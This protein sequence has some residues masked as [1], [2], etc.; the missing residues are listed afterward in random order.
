MSAVKHWWRQRVS[1]VV[2]IPL[3]L[4]LMW[5]VASVSGA[6]YAGALAF[7]ANPG[8]ALMVVLTVAVSAWHAV[9]GIQVVVEDYVHGKVLP[10]LL[11]W[12]TR[13]ACTLATLAACWAVWTVYREAVI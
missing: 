3:S 10:G 12:L 5:S 9:L 4:W 8:N 7:L 6:N 1:S 2:L 13:L 11:L